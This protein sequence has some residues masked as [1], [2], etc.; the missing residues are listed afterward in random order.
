MFYLQKITMVMQVDDDLFELRKQIRNNEFIQPTTGFAMERVQ[1]NI[2]ILPKKHAYD[3][4]LFCVRNPKSCPLLEVTDIG[5]PYL[6]KYSLTNI[7]I[8]TDIPKY[9]VFINGELVDQ[10]FDIKKYW[11]DDLVCFLLGCSFTFEDALIKNEI[12]I[13]N[14]TQGKNVAMYQTNIDCNESGVFSGKVVVSMRPFHY[15]HIPRVFEITSKYP[16]VHGTPIHVGEPK[17]IGIT[18]IHYPDYGDPIEISPDEIPVFWACGVTPQAVCLNSKPEI[19][20][21]HAPGHMLIT[22][23]PNSKLAI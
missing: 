3:F 14:I 7:D 1:A 12:P 10:P 11:R 13:K 23:Y 15:S 8:R 6:H 19:M 21:T 16:S 20:I 17:A 18:D 2:V 22:D 4:L 5:S 9:H